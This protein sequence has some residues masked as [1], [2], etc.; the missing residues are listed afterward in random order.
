MKATNF[1]LQGRK[2]GFFERLDR[3]LCG[4]EMK[5]R[6]A[7]LAESQ[8]IFELEERMRRLERLGSRYY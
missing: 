3:W 4:Q 1:L 8:D 2:P 7:W 5:D 6:E